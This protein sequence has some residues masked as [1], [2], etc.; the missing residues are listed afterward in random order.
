VLANYTYQ[1]SLDN[2]APSSGTTGATTTGGGSNPPLPW[3][4]TGNAPLDYGRSDF[5]RQ[6][7]FVLSYVWQTP[8]LKGSNKLVRAWP[9]TGTLPES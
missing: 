1:K 2:V 8:A 5:D 7:V 4:L 6:N 3:Y 9:A